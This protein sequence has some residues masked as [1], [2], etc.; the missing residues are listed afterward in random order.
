MYLVIDYLATSTRLG[1]ISLFSDFKL[2]HLLVV[3]V[4]NKKDHW[5][6][7]TNLQ[8]TQTWRMHS[9]SLRP[10]V[11]DLVGPLLGRHATSAPS[12]DV[13][14]LRTVRRGLVAR[15]RDRRAAAVVR[16]HRQARSPST[17]RRRQLLFGPSLSRRLPRKSG[18]RLQWRGNIMTL[19]KIGLE[20]YWNENICEMGMS[21]I[22][23]IAGRMLCNG[24]IDSVINHII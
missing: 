9:G 15:W 21:K 20:W 6:S 23:G 7:A 16:R 11:F 12:R 13:R 4:F 19:K 24:N 22:K 17:S 1:I 14:L 5:I 8:R 10:R 2:A 3:F 18:E